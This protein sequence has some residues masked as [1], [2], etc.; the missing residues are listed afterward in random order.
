MGITR[1][2]VYKAVYVVLIYI[3]NL[4]YE[5]CCHLILLSM[6]LVEPKGTVAW[7][8][9]TRCNSYIKYGIPKL[10]KLGK[11]YAQNCTCYLHNYDQTHTYGQ[12]CS[13]SMVKLPHNIMVK[14]CI[15]LGQTCCMQVYGQAVDRK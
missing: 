11:E 10:P 8:V 1:A 4:I 15:S 7:Y 2:L 13:K 6:V 9:Y 12:I 3:G 5:F 14:C